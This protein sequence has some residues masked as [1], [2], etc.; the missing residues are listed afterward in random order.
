MLYQHD[1][2]IL[3][4]RK[5]RQFSGHLNPQSVP[6]KMALSICLCTYDTL[7]TEHSFSTTIM[8]NVRKN[9]SNHIEYNHKD[10]MGTV[11]ELDRP[12]LYF[13]RP[14]LPTQKQLQSY[15]S[16]SG[17]TFLQSLLYA[18]W[19]IVIFCCTHIFLDFTGLNHFCVIIWYPTVTKLALIYAQ[20]NPMPYKGC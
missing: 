20:F 9:F 15:Q 6:L 16:Y 10:I 11:M 18:F 13:T 3:H 19:S 7:T 1:T 14:Q 17:S 4:A 12:F 5:M 2:N 8:G